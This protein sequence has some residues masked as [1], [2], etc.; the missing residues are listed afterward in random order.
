IN[1]MDRPNMVTDVMGVVTELKIPLN[2]ID[3]ESKKDGTCV[4]HMSLLI[5]DINLLNETMKRLRKI[6]SVTDVFR[7]GNA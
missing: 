6:T 3:A 1:A 7:I 2:A 5:R 4:V